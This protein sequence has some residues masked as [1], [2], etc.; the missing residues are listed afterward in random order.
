MTQTEI[1]KKP[2]EKVDIKNLITSDYSKQQLAKVLPKHI[3]PDRYA[4]IVLN[5]M[6]RT[7]KL[8][9]CTN[10]SILRCMMDLSATG[11]E[12]DG[13]HA[14]FIP[15]ENR[16]KGTVEC[17]L[18][19]DYKGFVKMALESEKIS[20]IHGDIVCE[21]D[22]FDYAHGTEPYLRHKPARKDRGD[23]TEAYTCVLF[24]DGTTSY[25]VMTLD[26][27]ELIRKRS[28]TYDKKSGKNYGPWAT[29][30][31]EMAKKTVFRR[32]SKWLP[33]GKEFTEAERIDTDLPDIAM[34]A[35]GVSMPEALPE[36]TPS[37]DNPKPEP[38]N[39]IQNKLVS[40][41]HLN[42]LRVLATEAK[43][44]DDDLIGMAL[45]FGCKKDLAELTLK[46]YGELCQAILAKQSEK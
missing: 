2:P 3:T 34:P 36:P 16:K 33:L 42:A 15:F 5:A 32:H 31:H 18:I 24:K 17:T 19:I 4:R 26:E 12:P 30:Y 28:K 40:E 27:I 20:S 46:N 43:L 6:I 38:V 39:D 44:S 41:G 23:I 9:K 11:L 25:E 45:D 7:P 29:D 21:N 13:R 8:A 10:E 22:Q 37:G 1:A 35:I 14:H